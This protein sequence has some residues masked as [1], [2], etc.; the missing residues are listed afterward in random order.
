MSLGL[1]LVSRDDDK[2]AGQGNQARK[3]EFRRHGFGHTSHPLRRS[4]AQN[5]WAK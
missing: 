2:L 1:R 3:L 5:A 4:D